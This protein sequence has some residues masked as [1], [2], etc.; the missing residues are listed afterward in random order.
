MIRGT[1]AQF[2]F[3]LPYAY[4]EL[5]TVRIVFWQTNNDGPSI[6]RPLPIVK[7]LDYCAPTSVANELTVTLNQEETLRFSDERKASCQLWGE[8][9][10]GVPFASKERLVAV[11]P[12]YDDSIVEDDVLPT[13]DPEGWVI[14]DG[15]T[16]T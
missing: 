7:T 16:I 10:E 2:K 11:Y 8:T 9:K 12:I 6:D 4:S 15:S 5:T 3:I 14:L 13:P 1:N